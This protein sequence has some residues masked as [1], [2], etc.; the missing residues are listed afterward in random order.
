MLERYRCGEW[1]TAEELKFITDTSNLMNSCLDKKYV[2]STI[3]QLN[4]E[5][6]DMLELNLAEKIIKNY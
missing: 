6:M 1:L 4:P 2:Q 5:S 3:N